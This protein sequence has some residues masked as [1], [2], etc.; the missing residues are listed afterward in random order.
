[1][2]NY[3]FR[4]WLAPHLENGDNEALHLGAIE[5]LIDSWWL[6]GWESWPAIQWRLLINKVNKV[7]G[8]EAG[9]EWESWL[10]AGLSQ[11]QVLLC[12]RFFKLF[13]SVLPEL[14]VWPGWSVPDPLTLPLPPPRVPAPCC[15]V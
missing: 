11:P 10:V 5:G 4:E 8:S 3:S 1:M 6:H 2:G 14:S 9:Q 13:L 15:P 7:R 12:P